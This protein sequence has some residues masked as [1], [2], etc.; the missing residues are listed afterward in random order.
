ME[1][2]R[3]QFTQGDTWS[4]CLLIDVNAS[5]T[6]QY[7]YIIADWR[8]PSLLNA[9]WEIGAYNRQLDLGKPNSIIICGKP[10][11]I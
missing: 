6:I 9:E 7:K 2:G 8:F 11:F 4:A 5:T 10:A 3:F 1:R